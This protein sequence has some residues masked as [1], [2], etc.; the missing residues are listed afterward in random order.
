MRNGCPWLTEGQEWGL[1]HRGNGAWGCGKVH[2][3]GWCTRQGLRD[4]HYMVLHNSPHCTV[5]PSRNAWCSLLPATSPWY[6][7]MISAC[8]CPAVL[9]A[10]QC[11]LPEA[12]FPAV[13]WPTNVKILLRQHQVNFTCTIL[14]YWLY[15][16]HELLKII[17]QHFCSIKH[18][19]KLLLEGEHPKAYV[20]RIRLYQ[21]N[22]RFTI[23]IPCNLLNYLW[24][25]SSSVSIEQ[26][27][28]AIYLSGNCGKG[29][30]CT[31][32]WTLHMK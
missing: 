25:S 31:G 23:D 5:M 16:D 22:V 24:K 30:I 21:V 20:F 1:V 3:G 2:R 17:Q 7:L 13:P 9:I 11:P 18:S 10:N 27:L 32:N 15:K 14:C 29:S 28:A 6:P 12:W 4:H 26:G 8:W 19:W